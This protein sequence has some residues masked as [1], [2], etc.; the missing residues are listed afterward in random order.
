M[1]AEL[2]ICAVFTKY[3]RFFTLKNIQSQNVKH[4]YLKQT[5]ISRRYKKF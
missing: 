2:Y 3:E 4:I 5:I 1:L